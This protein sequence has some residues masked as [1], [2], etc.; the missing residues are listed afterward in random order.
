MPNYDRHLASE[1]ERE[2]KAMEAADIEETRINTRKP[3]YI[4]AML[5]EYVTL[6]GKGEP[7]QVSAF[8]FEIWTDWLD[9]DA[10]DNSLIETV[11]LNLAAGDRKKAAQAILESLEQYMDE[12]AAQ[13]V[14]EDM[15]L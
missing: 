4:R 11:R 10:R 5:M 7:R 3:D 14:R 6:R 8:E 12:W 2:E 13:A 15:K 1:L 9:T